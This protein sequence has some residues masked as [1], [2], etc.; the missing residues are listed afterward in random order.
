[1]RCT[2]SPPAGATSASTDQAVASG[3]ATILTA[4]LFV[5][6]MIRPP[7]RS[8]LFPY[9]ALF[10]SPNAN[11]NSPGWVTKEFDISA[12]VNHAPVASTPLGT[13][14]IATSQ[15]QTFQ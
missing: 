13:N 6:L 1:M 9:T 10:R 3:T 5:F 15:G 14:I 11:V 4:A 2:T 7:P 8:T 12:P